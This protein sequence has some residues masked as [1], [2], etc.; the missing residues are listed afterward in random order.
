MTNTPIATT[1]I[2]TRGSL[3]M[4]ESSL[5]VRLSA[6]LLIEGGV[7]KQFVKLC[8]AEQTMCHDKRQK[9]A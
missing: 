2:I 4:M 1:T 7:T 9:A 3:R 5:L 6:I 8:F